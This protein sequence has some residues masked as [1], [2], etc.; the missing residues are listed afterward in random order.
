MRWR[1]IAEDLIGIGIDCEDPHRG[2]AT[3]SSDD[4]T[5]KQG[6][7]SQGLKGWTVTKDEKS[8]QEYG[9]NDVAPRICIS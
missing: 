1:R 8:Y 5:S 2:T 7:A 9:T 4:D 6:F 3:G